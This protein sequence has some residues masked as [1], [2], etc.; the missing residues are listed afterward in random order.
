MKK[1]AVVTGGSGGIGLAFAELLA[2]DGYDL[3]LTARD[4]NRL[5]KVSD[6]LE[7]TYNVSVKYTALD[8]SQKTAADKLWREAADRNVDV[9]I[10]NAGFGD[11]GNVVDA[12]WEKLEKMIELNITALTRL[13]QLAA[14]SMVKQGSGKIV[15]VASIAA[16]FPGAKMATY[17][18]TKAYVLSFSEAL[19]VEL[20]KTGVSITALC[21]GPT[22][23][24]FQQNANAK[25]V[26]LFKGNIPTA[27]Q[28][29][30]YGYN[31]MKNGKVIAVPGLKNKLFTAIVLPRSWKRNI[32][33]RVQ[34]H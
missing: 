15:N 13:S 1:Y 30:A 12:D 31:A 6:N 23:T 8:L 22:A 25:G 4:K 14:S 34:N 3:L 11:Y 16:F 26:S 24:D 29:A 21:P 19:S 20:N 9:L 33:D 5:K 27:E 28:V 2:S 10:N 18:A 17:Y 7:K 32:V